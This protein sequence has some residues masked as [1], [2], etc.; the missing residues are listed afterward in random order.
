MHNITAGQWL[1]LTLV[2]VLTG[3]LANVKQC[4]LKKR[5]K[6]EREEGRKERRKGK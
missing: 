4:A 3:V 2:S 5:R 6:G 1:S